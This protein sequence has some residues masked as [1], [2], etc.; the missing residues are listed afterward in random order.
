MNKPP[1]IGVSVFKEIVDK[2]LF[3][4]EWVEKSVKVALIPRPRCFGKTLNLSMLRYFFEKSKEDT[5]YLFRGLNI[6][7]HAKYREMQGRFPTIF[8][9]LKDRGIKRIL[10]LGFGFLGKEVLIHSK[11]K[12]QKLS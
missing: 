11:L 3:I 6:W 9:S 8:I 10:Y 1:P 5:S 7:N 4:E 2:T 12:P